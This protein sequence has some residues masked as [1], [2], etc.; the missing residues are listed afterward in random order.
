MMIKNCALLVS[1]QATTKMT[2]AGPISIT[3]VAAAG[4]F[5]V[6]HAVTH[7]IKLTKKSSG[8]NKDMVLR[9]AT[10]VDSP[11]I[12]SGEAEFM[13][14]T[15]GVIDVGKTTS[16]SKKPVKTVI[17]KEFETEDDIEDDILV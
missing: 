7:R 17:E 8:K 3:T 12:P 10:V 13:L 16:R 15:Q 11:F 4:G 2:M 6:A 1:N 9:K 5:A 14:T